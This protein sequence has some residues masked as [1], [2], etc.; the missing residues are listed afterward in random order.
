MESRKDAK[1]IGKLPLELFREDRGTELV[2]PAAV[3]GLYGSIPGYYQKACA[4][5]GRRGMALLGDVKRGNQIWK[6]MAALCEFLAPCLLRGVCK[7][8]SHEP[9]Y[10]GLQ[11]LFRWFVQ[12]F[13][14]CGY[15][16]LLK[17]VKEMTDW[18]EF[19]SLSPENLD[20]RPPTSRGCLG[21]KGDWLVY[22]WAV[23]HFNVLCPTVGPYARKL[24]KPLDW[25]ASANFQLHLAKRGFGLPGEVQ[26]QK[27]LKK[28]AEYLS[29]D[30]QVP[31]TVTSAAYSF[32]FD[33][34]REN[35]GLKYQF[36][37]SVGSGACLERSHSRG[38]R[39]NFVQSIL[40]EFLDRDPHI[41]VKCRKVLMGKNIFY[42]I[43]GEKLNLSHFDGSPYKKMVGGSLSLVIPYRQ[44]YGKITS[45]PGSS[46]MKLRVQ[47]YETLTQAC[48]FQYLWDTQEL[49]FELKKK[50]YAGKEHGIFHSIFLEDP[51]LDPGN[52]WFSTPE[53]RA[54]AVDDVGVKARVITVGNGAWVTLGH[55]YRTAMY[56]VMSADKETILSEFADGAFSEWFSRVNQSGAL[57]DESLRTLSVDLSSATDTFSKSVC[58][59]LAQGS[60]DAIKGTNLSHWRRVSIL[61]QRNVSA[62]ANISYPDSES[63]DFIIQKCGVLMGNAESW[64]I[65]NLYNRFFTRL[66]ESMCRIDSTFS[67]KDWSHPIICKALEK[68][69]DKPL[70]I[71]KRCGDDQ[72]ILGPVTAL[73]NYLNVITLSGA[74]PSPG[75]NAISKRFMTFTQSLCWVTDGGQI[76]W[77]DI[78]RIISL[79]DWK[80]INRLPAIKEIP[81]IWFRGLSYYLALRWWGRDEWQKSVKKGLYLFGQWIC[82]GFIKR[83][84]SIGLEPFLPLSLGGLN[85]PHPAGCELKHVRPRI[86]RAIGYLLRDDQRPEVFQKRLSLD[87]WNLRDSE[88]PVAQRASKISDRVFSV[89]FNEAS[90]LDLSKDSLEESAG[91]FDLNQFR[92]L[93]GGTFPLDELN[94]NIIKDGIKTFKF[95]PIGAYWKSVSS[96]IRSQTALFTKV[97]ESDKNPDQS[98]TNRAKLFQKR[99]HSLTKQAGYWDDAFDPKRWSS[100]ELPFL[101][102]RLLWADHFIFI[103]KTLNQQ[104]D[105]YVDYLIEETRVAMNW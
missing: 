23:G 18:G 32:A 83:C 50:P 20:D 47:D 77:I 8:P 87:I 98:I 104:T 34:T 72:V 1:P 105:G 97:P 46:F 27:A 88:N 49:E 60:A 89:I 56:S 80:G 76:D 45:I 57:K 61:V 65:L 30:I 81:R 41:V 31:P 43:W 26:R 75:T 44:L 12:T 85:F 63:L 7:H 51:S 11:T 103:S 16:T 69:S 10:R 19:Y 82:S 94:L 22:P 102:K 58:S 93:T 13:A 17:Y 33:Y 36:S 71:T 35:L 29:R 6:A 96:R 37:T 5:I 52:V 68:F 14:Y 101:E 78:V 91:W 54:E 15:D 38:G 95:V 42:N 73:R 3:L 64:T 48:L 99:V 100:K 74:I 86:L 84:S 62:N 28:H 25:Y 53:Y 21:S 9:T 92:T 55:L 4:H 66:G 90:R 2:S 39:A 59:A 40:S 24:F 79:V 67:P 70:C